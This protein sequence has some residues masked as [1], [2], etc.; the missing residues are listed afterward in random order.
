MLETRRITR[1]QYEWAVARPLGLKAGKLY[2]TIRE[3]YFFSYVREQLIAEYGVATVRSGGLKV[4]T[5]IH[6]RFQR[7]AKRA[8]TETLYEK[9]DPAAAVISIN[10]ANGAIRAMTA[11]TPGTRKN[12]FN[13]LSQARRQAGSTFKTFVLAA[14]V[15]M[16]VNPSTTGYVSA[17]FYYRPD[18][19]GNCEDGSWWCVETYSHSYS[20]WTSIARATLASDNTVYAQLTLDVTPERVGRMAKRL[21]VQTELRVD[22]AYVPS[23]GLGSIAVSPLDMASGVR[24]ARRGR[25]RLRADGDPARRAPGREGRRQRRLGQEALPPRAQPGR[26]VRRHRDPRAERPVRHGHR[27]LIRPPGRRQDRDDRRSCRRLVRGYTPRL[28]TTVWVGYPKGE[29]PMENVHGISVSG[30]SFPAQI[31]RLFMSAAIGHLEPLEFEDPADEPEWSTLEQGQYARSF[32]Y[33][34]DDDDDYVAPRDDG[35][36]RDADGSRDDDTGAR[37]AEAA[38]AAEGADAP[39]ASAP[40]DAAAS[41]AG[42]AACRL[43]RRSRSSPEPN[44]ARGPRGCVAH[45]SSRRRL[46]RRRL[47]RGG[48]ARPRRRGPGRRRHRL[49]DGLPRLPRGCV[50]ARIS[51]ALACCAAARRA[52]RRRRCARGRDPAAA[53]R[54]AAAAL[55]RRLGVLGVRRDRRRRARTRTAT[56]RARCRRTPRTSTRA[57]TGAT[58]SRSTGRS[59]RS[60]PKASPRERIVR[61]GGRL[62]LQGRRRALDARPHLARGA[63]LAQPVYAAAFVGWNPLLA[64]HFAGGGHNDAL[65]LALVLGALAFAAA[66]RRI[67][68]AVAWALSIFVKWVPV[69][70]FALRAIHARPTGRPVSHL[71]FAITVVAVALVATWRYGVDWLRAFGPLARNAGGQT[72]YAIPHR[73]ED[74]GVPHAVALGLATVALVLG[75]AWLAR[76]AHRGRVRLARAAC[77]LLLTTP[78]LAPWYTVWAVPLAAAEDD[79]RAQLV[80]LALCAYLL[81]QTIPL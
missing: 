46:C 41:A 58:R 55:D 13:L 52:A 59:S 57:S 29:I 15:D 25:R 24:D 7:V 72:S 30:G 51:L 32:G 42:R 40:C 2:T 37:R 21:G 26:G 9:T 23:M 81:P 18:P 71:G 56:R 76:E 43:R 10:P 22:G 47:G 66:G 63:A 48:S 69:V 6:P 16:G 64:V 79:R 74:L 68:A 27:S 11:V 45:A 44:A 12:Q 19:N 80:S 65:M 17:P 70:F 35:D 78:W 5:T 1:A 38:S 49:G 31:W 77:L 53:A 50:R 3:P 20:G 36:D 73:L 62:D 4:Y 75:L 60:S 8:I 34:D 61:A 54:R 14:A 28:Q 33:Y 67:A 39:A